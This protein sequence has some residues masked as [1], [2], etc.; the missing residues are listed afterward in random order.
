MGGIGA[1]FTAL[2]LG[3]RL[4]I[5]GGA[6]AA[7]IGLF[8]SWRNSIYESGRSAAIEEIARNDEAT[9]ARAFEARKALK[10]CQ[11]QNRAWDQTTGECQ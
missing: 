10:N 5:I 4:A 3:I 6:L 1:A 8:V 11:A 2:S 7:G 9:V